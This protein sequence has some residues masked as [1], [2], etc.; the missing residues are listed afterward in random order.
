[1]IVVRIGSEERTYSDADS[2]WV[3]QQIQRRREAGTAPCVQVRIDLPGLDI[4]LG[5]LQCPRGA[6]GR[7]A[8]PAEQRI[9]DAWMKHRLDRDAEFSPGA[10]VAFLK[11]LG[12]L[13]D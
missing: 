13:V 6:G 11:E 5:T 4:R 8:R 10:V 12:R 7:P 3:A 9:I 2:Q 1:M